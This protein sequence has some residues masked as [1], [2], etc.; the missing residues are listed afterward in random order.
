MSDAG[1]RVT[2]PPYDTFL[3]MKAPQPWPERED[4]TKPF[5]FDG[6]VYTP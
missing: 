6:K 3:S 1:R 5:R 2:L 4:L